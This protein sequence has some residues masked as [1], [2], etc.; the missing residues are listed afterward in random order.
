[1]A[2]SLLET[3]NKESADVESKILKKEE[4]VGLLIEEKKEASAK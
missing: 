3:F 2:S 1:M 4:I